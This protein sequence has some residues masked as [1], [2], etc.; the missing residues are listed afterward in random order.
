MSS[1]G[2]DPGTPMTRREPRSE[3]TSRRRATHQCNSQ[4]LS[5]AARVRVPWTRRPREAGVGVPGP[6]IAVI[7][8]VPLYVTYTAI[9]YGAL[10][11]VSPLAGRRH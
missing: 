11:L 8:G 3:L 2:Q 1:H 4:R 6:I 9:T 7:A 10:A 5:A